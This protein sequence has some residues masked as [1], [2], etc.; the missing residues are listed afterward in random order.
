MDKIKLGVFT[1]CA[2]ICKPPKR[3]N[4][5]LA[6]SIHKVECFAYRGGPRLWVQE[7]HNVCTDE[8]IN[9]LLDVMF[10]GASQVSTWYIAL[11]SNNYTPL[12]TNTY[13]VPGYTEATIYDE[14]T[15]PEFVEA[16]ASSKVITNSAS[17]AEFTMN[18]SAT[19][20]G[21]A[22][23]SNNTKG[24]TAASGAVLYCSAQFTYSQG[25]VSGNV[26]NVTITIT[27]ADT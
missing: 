1:K 17:T 22:L 25:V 16:A 24:D 11:F 3:T 27:G 19:I 12:V 15:R 14:A 26:L 20:Y 21:S 10:H 7:N 5:F 23:V 9:K 2:V 4:R 8:G 6:E 18:G 13:A